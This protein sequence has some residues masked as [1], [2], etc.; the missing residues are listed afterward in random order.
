MKHLRLFI[1]CLSAVLLTWSEAGFAKKKRGRGAGLVLVEALKR[2]H[3]EFTN[4][5][6]SCYATM[7]E[8]DIYVFNITP[9]STVGFVKLDDSYNCK[10]IRW[11]DL[12]VRHSCL[13]SQLDWAESEATAMLLKVKDPAHYKVRVQIQSLTEE[14]HYSET[15]TETVVA[16]L[17]PSM[18]AYAS[19]GE[20][21][22]ELQLELVQIDNVK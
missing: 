2:S 20:C 5:A 9:Q 4:L 14:T 16:W 17:T 15:W 10:P 12:K 6:F 19:T 13:I 21:D 3:V 7:D 18:S 11:D 22:L 1:L 8:N